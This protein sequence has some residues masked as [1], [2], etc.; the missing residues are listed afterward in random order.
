MLEYFLLSRLSTSNFL[1]DVMI[2]LVLIPLVTYLTSLMKN[3]APYLIKQFYNSRWKKINF[4]GWE[5]FLSGIYTFDYPLPMIAI[6]HYVITH[7]LSQNIRQ[8]NLE[9]N[10]KFSYH[11]LETVKNDN[12]VVLRVIKKQT[13]SK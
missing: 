11:L 10:S 8:I 13:F 3:D 4:I 1:Y 2:I 9:K 6:C 7:N 12:K 5:S